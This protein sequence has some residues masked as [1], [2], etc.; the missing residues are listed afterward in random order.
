MTPEEHLQGV[1]QL[2]GFRITGKLGEGGMGAVWRAVQLGTNRDVAI[3]TMTTS[4]LSDQA[5]Q[6]FAL[7][8]EVTAQLDHPNIGRLYESQITEGLC[9]YAM[10][11]IDGVD[12][13]VWLE[14]NKPAERRFL[15]IML[16]VCRAV[17]FAHQKGIIHRDLKPGNVMVT[18]ATEPKVVDFGLAKLVENEQDQA[19]S[20]LTS[21]GMV[22]GT[23]AYM[24]PEQIKAKV[25]DIDTRTDVFALGVMLYEQLTGGQHPHGDVDNT[26]TLFMSVVREDPRPPRA[27][28]KDMSKDLEAILLKAL[29]R[30]PAERYATAGDLAED[31]E[32]YLAGEPVLAQPQTALYVFRKKVVKNKGKV[33]LAAVAFLSFLVMAVGSYVVVLNERDAARDARQQAEIER[34]KAEAR[35]AL[36]RD[37]AHKLIFGLDTDL[38][39]GPTAARAALVKNA[40]LYLKELQK[41]AGDR[42]DL[43]LEIARLKLQ[44][45][46]VQRDQGDL[47]GAVDQYKEGKKVLKGLEGAEIDPPGSVQWLQAE[48]EFY[49]ARVNRRQGKV[50]DARKHFKRAIKMLEAAENDPRAS[51][52]LIKVYRDY[53]RLFSRKGDHDKARKNYKAAMKISEKMLKADKKDVQA[54]EALASSH[55]TLG[56][57]RLDEGRPSKALG[58]YKDSLKLRKKLTE[59]APDSVRYRKL[60]ASGYQG[61]GWVS[62]M[63]GNTQKAA[64]SFQK[65]L[66]LHQR[67]V[68]ND[69]SNARLKLQLLWDYVYLSKVQLDREDLDAAIDDLKEALPVAKALARGDS[70]NKTVQRQLARTLWMLGVAR[71][72]R[73][74]YK[75]AGKNLSQALKI[76]SAQ[77]KANPKDAFALDMHSFIL[78]ALGHVELARGDEKEAAGRFEEALKERRTLVGLA[79]EDTHYRKELARALLDHGQILASSKAQDKAVE[80]FKEGEEIL[81][82]LLKLDDSNALAR[83]PYIRTLYARGKVL[84]VLDKKGNQKPACAAFKA[85]QR[86]IVAHAA[87]QPLVPSLKAQSL[88]LDTASRKCK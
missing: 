52:L 87:R 78:T 68:S 43:M 82:A 36:G 74:D 70:A 80:A 25:A 65:S 86:Q 4:R 33:A 30:E 26:M 84:L 62:E 21:D 85:A 73:K 3:K 22:M 77:V 16:G 37:F 83:D 57:L 41:D 81:D 17:Q 28:N 10:E 2:R 48:A 61:M 1:P 18:T 54:M 44:I 79:P 20:K 47:E 32:R 75:R 7:E 76:T 9:Y 42:P 66:E 63:Q 59:L 64:E 69:P 39:E 49:L 67:Q 15:E 35:F 60:L 31:I 56:A 55:S 72:A 27:F 53:G 14:Q 51:H 71:T 58:H 8:I 12:L 46:E 88:A 34:D 19:S 5:R 24:S 11:Y 38:Q 40:L 6:R 13:E 23:P 29:A 50:D 45:G